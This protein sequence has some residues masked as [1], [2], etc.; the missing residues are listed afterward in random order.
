MKKSSAFLLILLFMLG[1]M[2]MEL[3]FWLMGADTFG[4]PVSM[5]CA[6]VSAMFLFS[7]A[8]DEKHRMEKPLVQ[9]G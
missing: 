8:W 1:G 6:W 4:F 2:L 7:S 3:Y 9:K 5:V